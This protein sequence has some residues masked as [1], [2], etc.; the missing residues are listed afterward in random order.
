[1][2]TGHSDG[3]QCGSEGDL[4]SQDGTSSS[5][6]EP[7]S[8]LDGYPSSLR[9]ATLRHSE[10]SCQD[11]VPASAGESAQDLT[12]QELSFP[13][14]GRGGIVEDFQHQGQDS[15][16]TFQLNFAAKG[17]AVMAAWRNVEGN[18]STRF[19]PFT[20]VLQASTHVFKLSQQARSLS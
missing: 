13:Q 7:S 17:A 9:G 19:H 1:M 11:E 14:A 10:S 12:D 3:F 2:V 20:G 18:N 4:S 16:H 8:N 6:N 5:Q 15:S